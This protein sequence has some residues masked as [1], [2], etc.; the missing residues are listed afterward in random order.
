MPDVQFQVKGVAT[1]DAP[2]QF[3]VSGRLR[4]RVNDKKGPPS[5]EIT[6]RGSRVGER[7]AEEVCNLQTEISAL[8]AISW[9]SA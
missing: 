4:D 3:S 2:C 7:G 9:C 8:P 1:L 5:L 6:L